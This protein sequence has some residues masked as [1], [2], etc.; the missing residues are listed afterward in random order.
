MSVE[1]YKGAEGVKKVEEGDSLP[2]IIEDILT[3]GKENYIDCYCA[4]NR[5]SKFSFLI[6][7]IFSHV[8]SSSLELI[9]DN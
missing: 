8:S 6:F 4:G 5:K 2:R 9:L 3:I 1:I 7:I